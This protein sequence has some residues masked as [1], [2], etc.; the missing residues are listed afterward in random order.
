MMLIT[1]VEREKSVSDKLLVN[2]LR[3]WYLEREREREPVAYRGSAWESFW[4]FSGL[5]LSHYLQLVLPVDK[6]RRKTSSKADVCTGQ[7][8]LKLA[9]RDWRWQAGGGGWPIRERR[10]FPAEEVERGLLP[11]L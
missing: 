5:L 3:L 10:R 7:W 1:E 4:G 9:T 11:E 8:I 2:I 6:S